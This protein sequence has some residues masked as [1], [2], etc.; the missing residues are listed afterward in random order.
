MVGWMEIL[1]STKP[2][3]E[4]ASSIS[5][6]GLWRPVCV[7]CVDAPVICPHLAPMVVP[8]AQELTEGA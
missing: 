4:P 7:V 5:R 1:L 6:L 8:S 2:T 3:P